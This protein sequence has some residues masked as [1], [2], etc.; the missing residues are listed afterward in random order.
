[1]TPPISAEAPDSFGRLVLGSRGSRLALA[2]ARWT[3]SKILA[4]APH[5]DL[6]IR[7]VKTQGDRSHAI[8]LASGDSVGWFVREI[9]EELLSGR[10][11]LAVHS[12]KDLPLA[13]PEDL[14][15]A[16]IPVREDPHDV[17]VTAKGV[18]LQR[19]PRGARVGTS[20]PR[21]MGQL[22]ALRSDLRFEPIR[23]NVDTRLRKLAAAQVDA[24][25]LAAAGLNRM[26]ALSNGWHPLPFEAM[27]PAPGQGALALE[28]R[29]RDTA[30]GEI[31]RRALDDPASSAEVRSERA[32]LK[33]LG[34]GCQMPVGALGRAK[35]DSLELEGVVASPD[36]TRV[37]RD[38]V[39]GNSRRPEE[40]GV[41]LGKRILAAGA[42]E[43][44]G[45]AEG[46]GKP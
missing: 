8:S 17:L 7:R 36:G 3:L 32:F 16:A 11:D 46:P 15:I 38:R 2:Q 42:A 12:L 34:G 31:L 20:S 23:G 43:I 40:A 4:A 22:L 1:M 33:T 6:E 21:R 45:P 19:L 10:I 14:L 44:L 5:L 28:I 27:L 13:Q 25:V 29:A 30:L 24:V 35:G 41:E 18:E 9:E 37:V 26:G 39:S